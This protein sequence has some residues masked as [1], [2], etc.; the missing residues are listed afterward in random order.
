MLGHYYHV[1]ADGTWEAA[2]TEHEK[3]LT[4]SGL[5]DELAFVRIGIVGAA[6]NRDAVR[7]ALTF[8]EVVVEADE[9]WEQVTLKVLRDWV[10]ENPK[11][12]RILYAHTKG[13]Y[14]DD[15]WRRQWRISMTHDTVTEWRDC[16]ER[17]QG[18]DAVGAFWMEKAKA[19]QENKGLFFG[20]NFWW[21]KSEYLA[22]LPPLEMD[23][24]FRAEDWIGLNRPKVLNLRQG[25]PAPGR[26]WKP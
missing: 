25:E 16:V 2:V 9:G 20:G 18:V 5:L 8:G 10:Q 26:F 6:K 12:S 1:W 23:T 3:A 19:H 21:A 22:S 17:L 15:D 4:D 14:T 13:A 7:A 24:R 11:R